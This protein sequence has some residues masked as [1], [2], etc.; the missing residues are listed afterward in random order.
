MIKTLSFCI[1]FLLTVAVFA[2][3]PQAVKPLQDPMAADI[4]KDVSQKMNALAT[5]KVDF[6]FKQEDSKSGDTV[7]FKGTIL[8]KGV[9]YHIDMGVSEI[10]Y[11]GLTMWTWVKENKEV[12]VIEIP[13]TGDNS[14]DFT[15]PRNLFTLYNGNYKYNYIGEETVGGSICQKIDLFPK[16]VNSEYTRMRV[17]VDGNKDQIKMV[18]VMSRNGEHFT[19]RIRSFTP[20]ITVTD[21]MFRFNSDIH[22]DVEVIDLRG[23]K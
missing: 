13:P 20:N 14:F 21:D 19:F 22:K 18:K 4:L 10:F 2:Q 12:N 6:V 5:M 17:W 1:L 23:V 15:N 9:K 7:S 11:D 3:Q 8:M 16:E